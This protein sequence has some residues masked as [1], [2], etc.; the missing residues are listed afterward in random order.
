V[1]G[2]RA[3]VLVRDALDRLEFRGLVLDVGAVSTP[4]PTL[5]PPAAGLAK[6]KLRSRTLLLLSMKSM[7]SR[8][9][10]APGSVSGKPRTLA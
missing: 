2:G 7:N 5:L 9:R 3:A 10:I 4:L 8:A 1:L 6:V